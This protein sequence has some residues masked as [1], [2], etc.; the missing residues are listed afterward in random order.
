MRNLGLEISI[1]QDRLDL[2]VFF[3]SR[4]VI[5]LILSAGLLSPKILSMIFAI[6]LFETSPAMTN[7]ILAGLQTVDVDKGFASIKYD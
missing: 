5:R 3:G 6:S 1:L 4:G 7:V 2:A